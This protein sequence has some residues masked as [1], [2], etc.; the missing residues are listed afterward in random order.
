[1]KALAAILP[2]I[3]FTKCLYGSA[4]ETASTY[5]SNIQNT[6]VPLDQ[7]QSQQ[8]P[9]ITP[10]VGP[11]CGNEVD[12]ILDA[13]F[14]WWYA[15]V[16][17]MPYAALFRVE[18]DGDT[19]N[20]Q[21]RSIQVREIYEFDWNWDPGLRVGLGVVTNYHGWDVYANWTYYYTSVTGSKSVPPLLEHT[22]TN[23][24]IGTE[25]LVT[26]WSKWGHGDLYSQIKAKAQLLF[27]QIDLS[28]GRNFWINP[29]MKLRPYTGIRGMWT[30]LNLIAHDTFLSSTPASPYDVNNT[31]NRFKQ[32]MWGVGLLA[33]LQAAWQLTQNWS[34]FTDTGVSLLYGKCN[35]HR[36]IDGLATRAGVQT[37]FHDFT[38]RHDD[39]YS[40]QAT[41][42][43]ALGLR[44]E[45]IF[46]NE[47]YRLMFDAGWES[48]YLPSFNHLDQYDATVDFNHPPASKS[49][50]G[51]L[52]L[53]GLVVRGRFDF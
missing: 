48:H 3:L 12:I 15:S 17:S 26:P 5:P 38:T 10:S 23:D 42:D 24:P 18:S 34:I 51:D 7:T 29:S 35:I 33:G 49:S 41:I 27:N 37:R 21:R 1:M 31:S 36:H 9:G 14:L 53:S 16:T 30:R 52:S 47:S 8:V 2:V 32:K 4:I 25:G 13:E 45:W 44:W 40:L 28:L 39:I 20:P 11:L 19:T 6:T 50:N 22:L 46:G 43:L